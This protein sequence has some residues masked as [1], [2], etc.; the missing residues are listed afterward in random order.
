MAVYT[1]KVTVHGGRQ[2]KVESTTGGLDV[3]LVM[4]KELGGGGGTG[5]NP[6][7][8][9]AAGYGACYQSALANVARQA[10]LDVKDT[11]IVNNVMLDKDTDGGFKLSVRMDI[12]IPG[13]SKEEATDI[14][15][16]AHEFCPYSKAIRGNIDVQLNIV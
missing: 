1:A 11:T 16:K 9:F 15:K 7:E 5:T 4:P 14:A 13:L 2:G 10:K 6:E 8:L 3:D 12:N